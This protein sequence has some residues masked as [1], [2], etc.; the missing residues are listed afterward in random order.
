MEKERSGGGF[1]PP[2]R[3]ERVFLYPGQERVK[4]VFLLRGGGR[5]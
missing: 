4:D 3:S 5:G 1:R 2:P